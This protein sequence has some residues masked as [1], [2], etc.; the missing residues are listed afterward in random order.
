MLPALRMDDQ[1]S[2]IH[3]DLRGLI[4]G[5]LLLAPIE[6]AA[7]AVD[8][9]IYEI[10]P[11]GVIVP[12]SVEDVQTVTRY[13]WENNIPVH[14]RGGGTGLAG[15]TLGRGLVLDFSRY[16]RR[17]LEI[18]PEHVVVQ[19]GVVVDS[20]NSQLAPMG[21]RLGP[22]PGGAESCTIGAMIAANAGGVRSLKYGITSDH[23]RSLELVFAHGETAQAGYD[24]WPSLEDDSDDFKFK[25]L[26]KLALLHKRYSSQPKS[27]PLSPRDRAGYAF[28]SA[29]KAEGIDL[30]R[31]IAGSEGT[32][33]IVIE[34]SLSTVPTPQ[35]QGVLAVSFDRIVSAAAAV[36]DCLEFFPSAC[37]L[38]DRRLIR[39]ARDDAPMLRDAVPDTSEGMLIVE[40]SGDNPAVVERDVQ[41]L[42]R[43]LSLREGIVADPIEL[44][45]RPECEWLLGTRKRVLP[46]LLRT[47][48][49]ARP[50]PLFEDAAAPVDALPEFLQTLQT[51]FKNHEVSGT[52]YAHAGAGQ[53]HA[54]P[55]L[56]LSSP[57]DRAKIEPLSD[58]VHAAVKS[59]RGSISG[60]HGCGLAR[61]RYLRSH[62]E[63]MYNIFREI[64]N[65]FDPKNI[66]NPGKIVADDQTSLL[67]DLRSY[68]S[69]ASTAEPASATSNMEEESEGPGG[70]EEPAKSRP[71]VEVL[72][73]TGG[74]LLEIANACN[75]CG[76]CRTSEPAMRMCPTFRA[77]GCEAASPKAQANLVR[78]IAS[79][80]LDP[81]LW[82]AEELKRNANLCVHCNMCRIECPSG[83]DV[84]KLMLEA[85]AAYVRNHGL[86]ASDW[87]LSRLDR[88]AALAGRFP[89][90]FNMV[91]SSRPARWLLER[92]V[93]LAR[94]RRMPRAR[95]TAFVK[96]AER[97]GMGK[98]KPSQPGPRVAYFVD[99]FAN[100][101]DHELADS[102]VAV[103]RTAGVNVFVPTGQRGS[104]MPALVSGDFEHARQLA[105]ANLRVLGN[106]V[107]DGYTIVCT[108]PTAAFMLTHEYP[109]L[110]DDL[111][112]SLVAAHTM[113]FGS[114][115]SGLNARGLLPAPETALN[116]RVGYH[117]PCHLR[118]LEIG[119]PGLDL[120]RAVPGL[121]VQFIDRGCSGMAGTFGLSKANFRTSLKAG[122]P[123]TNRL[124][125]PDLDLGATECGACRMQMEQAA[126][127]WTLHPA[128]IL[129]LGH[130]LNPTL[131][132]RIQSRKPKHIVD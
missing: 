103:L 123:L 20:L 62:Y 30:S 56:D 131:R 72:R 75:G 89:L 82:G 118:A 84:S 67:D 96:K 97:R 122:R 99:L 108:E 16:F 35:A 79:G 102:A 110:C 23:V 54:R 64:K 63:D 57:L 25:L 88:W 109:K 17:V 98:P 101:F 107:R 76:A 46:H 7:Y 24:A 113:D 105:L 93:G 51:I 69:V 3:D 41:E 115:L 13:A 22:D 120:V 132:Q 104:G 85:K 111:D 2:R 47:A 74:T 9:G 42:S 95:R 73:P 39:L 77:L 12:R 18:G 65:A 21:R 70:L 125:E 45:R 58:E 94:L 49:P 26:Q 66:L 43:R 19:P 78:Q 28:W 80:R 106:A 87:L 114:Y 15:E 10:D 112:A 60:E 83:V 48:L 31:L 129:A 100:H 14:A 59:L 71:L 34:A 124:L 68:P 52:I 53:V 127:K 11:L 86:T 37:E 6:R 29:A 92:T 44:F 61:T 116:A 130:G 50:I 119:T 32:L 1:R 55:F 81:K 128:K 121:D 27:L 33:A 90:T 126:P 8:A 4:S 36:V 38:L 40:F 117:Q 91:M 5:D